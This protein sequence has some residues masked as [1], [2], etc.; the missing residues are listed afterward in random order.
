[1]AITIITTTVDLRAVPPEPLA[2][3]DDRKKTT[4]AGSAPV[5]FSLRE[6][7]AALSSS[8]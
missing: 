6:N 8:S 3:R 5:L 1:M 4:G 7:A 2:K